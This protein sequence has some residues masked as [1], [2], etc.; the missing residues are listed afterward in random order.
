MKEEKVGKQ[1]VQDTSPLETSD[2]QYYDLKWSVAEEHR[3]NELPQYETGLIQRCPYKLQGKD[4]MAATMLEGLAAYLQSSEWDSDEMAELLGL[5]DT[6]P[7]KVTG[8]RKLNGGRYEFFVQAV[9]YFTTAFKSILKYSEEFHRGT[10]GQ[11]LTDDDLSKLVVIIL[12]FVKKRARGY[13]IP[14]I[15]ELQNFAYIISRGPV[16]EQDMHID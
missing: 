6:L 13:L 4:A 16:K 15:Y 9:S 14:P 12:D 2:D 3:V 11:E 1:A 10:S 7:P 8:I 5:A